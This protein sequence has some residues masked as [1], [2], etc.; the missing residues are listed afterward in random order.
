MTRELA[1]FSSAKD[2]DW[3]R[4][5]IIGMV[6]FIFSRIFRYSTQAKDVK[7]ACITILRYVL[8]LR[9]FINMFMAEAPNGPSHHCTPTFTKIQAPQIATKNK[10]CGKNFKNCRKFENRLVL[11]VRGVLRLRVP[12]LPLCRRGSR[13]GGRCGTSESKGTNTIFS[14]ST[15]GLSK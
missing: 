12:S 11:C 3:Q 5:L 6:D 4:K 14:S 9:D 2:V 10:K 7:L 15:Q 13:R 1:C 8:Q